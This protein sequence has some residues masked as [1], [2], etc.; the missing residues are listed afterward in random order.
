MS[1]NQRIAC[2][3]IAGLIL[4]VLVLGALL[5]GGCSATSSP[6]RTSVVPGES[7]MAS[8]RDERRP[9]ESLL[10]IRGDA[11]PQGSKGVAT[12]HAAGDSDVHRTMIDAAAQGYDA[13][14][15]TR[16]GGSL[17][18]KDEGFG[19]GAGATAE[20]DKLS[21][22]ISGA[23]PNVGL[24]DGRTASGGSI[25]RDTA[26]TAFVVP[27]A[28]WKNPML[29]IG[30]LAAIGGGYLT[31]QGMLKPGLILVAAG[32]ACMAVAFF[33]ALTLWLLAAAAAVLVASYLL[34]AKGSNSL[35]EALRAVVAGVENKAVPAEAQ[36]QVKAAI[37]RESD[38]PDRAVIDEIKR[39][40]GVGKYAD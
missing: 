15:W 27:E 39:A 38:E 1:K 17:R 16:D 24:G 13:E 40:D 18:T 36:A 8:E 3:V 25:E 21:D 28:P 31:F 29:W 7:R 12:T 14:F 11:L 37:A 26:G 5:S 23:A 35:R 22:T 33:P 4:T 32:S 34:S 30:L 9:T 6:A 2:V 10:R 19:R 20:G